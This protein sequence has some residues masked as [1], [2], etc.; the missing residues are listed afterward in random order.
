M[1]DQHPDFARLG[2]DAQYPKNGF[3]LDAEEAMQRDVRMGVGR[4]RRD[5]RRR[6]RRSRGD[7][8]APRRSPGFLDPADEHLGLVDGDVGVA[9]EG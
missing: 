8:D 3:A 9:D 6:S 4:D 1:L 7:P 2:I 5:R